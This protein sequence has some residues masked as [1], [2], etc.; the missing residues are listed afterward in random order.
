MSMDKQIVIRLMDGSGVISAARIQAVKRKN[1]DTA[2]Q[3]IYTRAG[4]VSCSWEF[5]LPQ[6]ESALA[7]S[8]AE[9]LKKVGAGKDAAIIA[10]AVLYLAKEMTS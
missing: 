3:L 7:L 9:E 10:P 2:L 8:V 5:V 4:H 1:G 6:H